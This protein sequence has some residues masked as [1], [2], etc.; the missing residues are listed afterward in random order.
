MSW[1]QR[2]ETP[3]SEEGYRQDEKNAQSLEEVSS[4]FARRIKV[5]QAA[6]ESFLEVFLQKDFAVQRALIEGQTVAFANVGEKFNALA[7][8]WENYNAGRS[9]LDYH[10][11]SYMQI[12]GMGL[13]VVPLLMKSM[14][15]GQS[16]WVYALKCIT[17]EQA[18]TSEMLG[19]RLRVVD[20]WLKWGKRN[21]YL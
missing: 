20:A 4:L 12:I 14:Q 7:E 10:Q 6:R 16:K 2:F 15:S 1:Q 18:D 9:I 11:I 13:T 3:R 21:D 19:D 8:A 17:G 5:M